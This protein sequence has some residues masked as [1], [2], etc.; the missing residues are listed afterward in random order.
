MDPVELQHKAQDKPIL[1]V[2]HR[3][4][5]QSFAFDKVFQDEAQE[6]VS[7]SLLPFRLNFF[8]IYNETC[9][10][11]VHP[12]L[13]GYNSCVFAYGTTVS[14]TWGKDLVN[15]FIRALEKPTQC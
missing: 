9:K 10:N 12:V 13:N 6:K 7:F 5:E 1:D 15:F 3:S 11:L 14:T 2:L 8:Q 4:K